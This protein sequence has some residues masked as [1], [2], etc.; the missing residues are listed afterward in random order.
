M[1]AGCRMKTGITRCESPVALASATG[2]VMVSPGRVQRREGAMKS[3]G[4][5]LP[6][7]MLWGA[8]CGVPPASVDVSAYDYRDTRDL[9]RFVHDAARLL[10]R[11]GLGVLGDPGR[12]P[13]WAGQSYLY[14]YGLDNTCLYHAG[15][16]ELVGK[17]LAD[18][19]DIEGKPIA[20]MVLAALADPANPH[21]WVH[22]SWWQPGKF[23]PVPKSSCHFKATLPDGRALYVGGGID[24][25][26][27]EREFIRIAVDSAVNLLDARGAAALQTLVD[28]L[29]PY[30]YRE[31]RVFAFRPGGHMLIS[32]VLGDNRIEMDLTACADEVGHRPFERA[33]R[34][35]D[36]EPAAWQIFMARSRTERQLVKKILYL[37]RTVLD[38]EPLFVGAITDLPQTP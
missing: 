28:P 36:T 18:I 6:V 15:M 14:V 26:H 12:C 25:P 33:V 22:Y 30:H 3:A 23:Y 32:S 16:P 38:G 17:N 31:V 20:Q 1:S 21:G 35:L 10:E 2:A 7:A 29:S 11:E 13:G 5:L 34:L 19:T 8:S 24:Y 27:E 37:R 9:V 4:W